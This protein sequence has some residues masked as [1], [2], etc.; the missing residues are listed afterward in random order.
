[1]LCSMRPTD[2]AFIA[3]FLLSVSLILISC[4]SNQGEPST[5]DRKL[6]EVLEPS[7]QIELKYDSIVETADFSYYLPSVLIGDERFTT[8]IFFDPQGEGGQPLSKYMELADNLGLALIGSSVSKNGL[9]MDLISDHYQNLIQTIRSNFKGSSGKIILAG[10]SGGAKVATQFGL[11]DPSVIGVVATGAMLDPQ[12]K[13]PNMPLALIAGKG[14][15]NHQSMLLSSL[16]LMQEKRQVMFQQ[17]GGTHEWCPL[18]LMRSSVQW[19][20]QKQ[21]LINEEER[22]KSFNK[23][24][25]KL[26]GLSG[27]DEFIALQALATAYGDLPEMESHKIRLQE[28]AS[29]GI[30]T[31]ELNALY[32]RTDREEATKQQYVEQLQSVDLIWWEKEI[33]RL[34]NEA[35]GESERAFQ[36]QRLLGFIGLYCYMTAD[37][38]L[39]Q[40]GS[41]P[42]GIIEVYLLAE[43][44]NPKAERMKAEVL[45]L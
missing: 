29:S 35:T 38:M 5:S 25:S 9:T 30:L 2:S 28:M 7:V 34:K 24:E 33:S 12:G 27:L 4:G 3:F 13:R 41:D 10:F 21:S 6:S 19:I 43:P 45:G 11:S 14:D 20:M 1:M 44:D 42:S 15:L 31:K 39:Q 26:E 22:T 16:Q 18:G 17:F 32:E 36:A 40:T 23:A 37:K 8:V